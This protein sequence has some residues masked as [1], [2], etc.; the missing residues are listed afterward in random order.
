MGN[1]IFSLAFEKWFDVDVMVSLTNFLT[2]TRYLGCSKNK[3]IEQVDILLI[4]VTKI[5]CVL[6][7]F[8]LIKLLVHIV[9]HICLYTFCGL[10]IEKKQMVNKKICGDELHK[11]A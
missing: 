9:L 1:K 11:K 8:V 2:F 5:S 10:N 3:G 7:C 4:R 6:H